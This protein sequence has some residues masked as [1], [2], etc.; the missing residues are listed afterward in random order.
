MGAG[1]CGV[2]EAV[3]LWAGQDSVLGWVGGCPLGTAWRLRG[4]EADLQ[5]SKQ[6]ARVGEALSW[7]HCLSPPSPRRFE[8]MIS[9]LHLGEI[10]RLLLVQL[11]QEKALHAGGTTPQ[12][13]TQGK[14]TALEVL[15]ISE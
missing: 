11:A 13:L 15:S 7:C 4:Q 9:S 3:E 8:K 1:P 12:L 2:R 6:R 10:A 5:G 14:V